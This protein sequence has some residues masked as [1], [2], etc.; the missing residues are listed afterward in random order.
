M[1]LAESGYVWGMRGE[2]VDVGGGDVGLSRG[3]YVSMS[4]VSMSPVMTTRCH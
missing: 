2:D 1:S 4:G 3:G